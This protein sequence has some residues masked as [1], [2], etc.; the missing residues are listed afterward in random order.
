MGHYFTSRSPWQSP[1]KACIIFTSS[2]VSLRLS[3]QDIKCY[4]THHLSLSPKGHC[5]KETEIVRDLADYAIWIL[6]HFIR[7]RRLDVPNDHS[8][9]IKV[10]SDS[11]CLTQLH[12]NWKKTIWPVKLHLW[13]DPKSF[14]VLF[15]TCSHF[16]VFSHEY[17]MLSDSC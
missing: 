2:Y 11:A 15:Y 1:W 7:F 9:N 12:S 17:L 6:S 5:T 14:L 16:V 8:T 3:L 13:N 4:I 10:V